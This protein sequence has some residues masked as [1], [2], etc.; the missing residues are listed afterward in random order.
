VIVLNGLFERTARR[1]LSRFVGPSALSHSVDTAVAWTV[2][3]VLVGSVTSILVTLANCSGYLSPLGTLMDGKD[4]FKSLK[5]ATGTWNQSP[6]GGTDE[7]SNS[8]PQSPDH[9]CD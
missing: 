9:R 7:K 6:H 8:S 4:S 3:L 5:S 2:R 1:L